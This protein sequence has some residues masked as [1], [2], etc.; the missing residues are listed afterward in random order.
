MYN[1]SRVK[2]TDRIGV[3]YLASAKYDPNRTVAPVSYYALLEGD[4]KPLQHQAAILDGTMEL[5]THAWS[6]EIDCLNTFVSSSSRQ[7][8]VG[9]YT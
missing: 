6:K 1:Y 8:I 9:Q 2:H 3:N 7:K 5:L 4:V